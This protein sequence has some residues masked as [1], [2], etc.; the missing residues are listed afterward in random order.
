M[1]ATMD[2]ASLDPLTSRNRFGKGSV[3][4]KAKSTCTPGNATRSSF[5][6][7]ISSRLTLSSW[8]SAATRAFCPAAALPAARW[9]RVIRAEDLVR[10]H[11]LL[12]G[13]EPLVRLG[14]IEARRIRAR[15]R[16]VQVLPALVVGSEGLGDR[17]QL[18]PHA[19][20]PA[21]VEDQPDL[22]RQE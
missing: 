10:V 11:A 3:S 9:D 7:S 15:L 5:R 19:G 1:S 22:E 20:A 12:H 6:S 21:L 8:L 16:E 18:L 17:V 4:R 2:S 14:A 13:P